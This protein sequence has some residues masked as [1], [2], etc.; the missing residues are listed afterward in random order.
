MTE[1]EKKL[2]GACDPEEEEVYKTII[3]DGVENS[4]FYRHMGL[5]VTGLGPGWATFKMPVGRRLWNVG[6][7]VHGGA[8][9]SIA[10]AAAGVALATLLDKVQERLITIEMKVNFC[11]PVREGSLLARGEVVQKGKRVAICEVEVTDEDDRLV[12]KGISTYMVIDTER[13]RSA[14]E[15]NA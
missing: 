3:R 9:T 14:V 11:A 4:P 8:I 12:A 7:I 2:W 1:G 10:D 6:N 13:Q 15:H 5:E